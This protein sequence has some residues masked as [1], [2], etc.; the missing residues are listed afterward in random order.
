MA[1]P[2]IKWRAGATDILVLRERGIRLE[3]NRDSGAASLEVRSGRKTILVFLNPEEAAA[4]L[5]WTPTTP[6]P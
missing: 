5:A 6:T 4:I 1:A 2:I 3:V